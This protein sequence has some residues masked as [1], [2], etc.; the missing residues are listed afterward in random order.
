MFLEDLVFVVWK[1]GRLVIVYE[2][3][4]SGSVGNNI[5]GEVG[6]RVFEYFEVFVGVVSGWE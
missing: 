1:I 4:W 5:V 3:G 2:V 6:R